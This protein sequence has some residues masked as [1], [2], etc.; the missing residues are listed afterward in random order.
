MCIIYERAKPKLMVRQLYLQLY[1]IWVKL[2]VNVNSK[3]DQEK[4]KKEMENEDYFS[5]CTG[6]RIEINLTPN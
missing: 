6:Y 2:F 4:L 1:E 5:L 3:M